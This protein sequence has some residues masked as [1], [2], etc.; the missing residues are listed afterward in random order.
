ME[1]SNPQQSNT[2]IPPTP[3]TP[4][5]NQNEPFWKNKWLLIGLVVITLLLLTSGAYYLGRNSAKDNETAMPT[6]FSTS[7]PTVNKPT[8]A[9]SPTSNPS[10]ISAETNTYTNGELGIEFN[11][12]FK[13]GDVKVEETYGTEGRKG[14]GLFINFENL[15]E[16]CKSGDTP[17]AIEMAS[18][19]LVEM[20][21]VSTTFGGIGTGRPHPLQMNIANNTN[22]KAFQGAN[23]AGLIYQAD[24]TWHK[25]FETR[26]VFEMKNSEFKYFTFLTHDE[27]G[28]KS[29]ANNLIA[30]AKSFKLL[31]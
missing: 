3:E 22:S 8:V 19:G 12:P 26:V 16:S 2:I 5:V 14:R 13:Y 24:D 31:K 11:Y 15:C 18:P 10:P 23:V 6:P 21:A 30:I 25:K 28:K 20:G 17:F 4:A 27:L 29:N 9:P 7:T 1:P